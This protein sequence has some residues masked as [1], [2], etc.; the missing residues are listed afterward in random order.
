[1][2]Q[3][4]GHLIFVFHMVSVP[5]SLIIKADVWGLPWKSAG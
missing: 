5:F 4:E 2:S 1:M 3:E